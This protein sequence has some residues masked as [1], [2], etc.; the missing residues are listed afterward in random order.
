MV[1]KKRI[2]KTETIIH[3]DKPKKSIPEKTKV[4]ISEKKVVAPKKKRRRKSSVKKTI[5]QRDIQVEKLLIENFVA[6]QKVMTTMAGK[7]DN[8]STQISKLLDIFELS[9]KSLAE[10]GFSTAEDRKIVGKLDSLL[11]QNKTF[12]KGIA[13]LHEREPPRQE[14]KITTPRVM[15]RIP[16]TYA[17]PQ[18]AIK[19]IVKTEYHEPL[20]TEFSENP[21]FETEM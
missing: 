10:R 21:K 8:L 16:Q 7:F 14:I 15:P 18:Q 1:V 17:Q 2:V 5:N 6:L 13:M 3:E 11:E 9:A 12:A 20:S 19:K 4:V